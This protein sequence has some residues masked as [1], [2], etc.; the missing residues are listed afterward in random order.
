MLTYTD[1]RGKWNCWSAIPWR[2]FDCKDHM[3]SAPEVFS[4]SSVDRETE[5]AFVHRTMCSNIRQTLLAPFHFATLTQN[6]SLNHWNVLLRAR[7]LVNKFSGSLVKAPLRKC[8]VAGDKNVV[9]NQWSKT[10]THAKGC[11]SLTCTPT[12]ANWI[13]DSKRHI[14][15]VRW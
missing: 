3:V 12:I 15:Q 14:T 1:M 10:C 2:P 4:E 11:R 13:L 5:L 9:R 7:K 6:I 8:F